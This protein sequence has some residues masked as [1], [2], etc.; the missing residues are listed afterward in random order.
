[1]QNKFRE[2]FRGLERNYGFC[3]LTNAKVNPETGKLE[4]PTRDYGWSGKPII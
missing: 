4:I 1:M 3:D 2:F